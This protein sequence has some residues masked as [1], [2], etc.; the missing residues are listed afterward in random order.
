MA[1]K[2][3]AVEMGKSRSRIAPCTLASSRSLAL[4]VSTQATASS[5]V[6][7]LFPAS[8]VNTNGKVTVPSLGTSSWRWN[9]NEVARAGVRT[10]MIGQIVSKVKKKNWKSPKQ[11]RWRRS[12][13]FLP[14]CECRAGYQSVP[15]CWTISFMATP[16]AGKSSI[17]FSPMT[18]TLWPYCGET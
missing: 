17:I 14:Y 9:S 6:E 5:I 4:F 3:S 11:E 15:S 10:S 18:T 13:Q 12:T 1:S 2:C 16:K 8:G 7:S